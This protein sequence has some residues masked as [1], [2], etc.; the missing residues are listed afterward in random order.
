M[1]MHD[2]RALLWL[3]ILKLYPQI[4]LMLVMATSTHRSSSSEMKAMIFFSSE[5]TRSL[6][7]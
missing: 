4:I 6:S 3:I 1:S 2:L 7:D 5:K